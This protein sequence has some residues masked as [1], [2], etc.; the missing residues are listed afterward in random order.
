M[1]VLLIWPSAVEIASLI[2]HKCA[3][4]LLVADLMDKHSFKCKLATPNYFSFFREFEFGPV[5]ASFLH[6][7]DM[8]CGYSHVLLLD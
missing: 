5:N 6:Q 1:L 7:A 3:V 2:R 8:I 4:C